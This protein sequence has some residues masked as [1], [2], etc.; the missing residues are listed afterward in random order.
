MH[1]FH[2]L[3]LHSDLPIVGE[4]HV[5]EEN[6]FDGGMPI[7]RLPSNALSDVD[8]VFQRNAQFARL[9]AGEESPMGDAPPQYETVA[10]RENA[11]GAQATADVIELH[12]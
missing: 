7:S 10:S 5:E 12:P 3:E 1:V 9:V 6:G 11:L 8:S 4:R 2:P